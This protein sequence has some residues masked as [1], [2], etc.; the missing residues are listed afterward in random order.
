MACRWATV[1]SGNERTKGQLGDKQCW[2]ASSSIGRRWVIS[3]NSLYT[4]KSEVRHEQLPP[5]KDAARDVSGHLQL[6]LGLVWAIQVLVDDLVHLH[7]STQ[8]SVCVLWRCQITLVK[9]YLPPNALLGSF[10][11]ILPRWLT[12]RSRA[13]ADHLL[14]MLAT[15]PLQALE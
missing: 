11:G 9:V 8:I 2:P 7:V 14:T 6:Q 3:C 5:C 10:E 12:S 4:S 15:G 13:A 1:I